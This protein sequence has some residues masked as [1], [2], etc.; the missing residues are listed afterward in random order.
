MW[1]VICICQFS[2]GQFS[3]CGFTPKDAWALNNWSRQ[4][5]GKRIAEVISITP[6]ELV[7]TFDG[8]PQG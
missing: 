2:Q 1:E 6:A 4:V 8:A 5:Q 3:Y 7:P